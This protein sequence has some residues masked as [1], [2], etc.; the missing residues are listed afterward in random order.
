MGASLESLSGSMNTHASIGFKSNF[1]VGTTA[2]LSFSYSPTHP[3]PYDVYVNRDLASLSSERELNGPRV[4]LDIYGLDHK[5][6]LSRIMDV[7]FEKNVNTIH[8]AEIPRNEWHV[9]IDVTIVD[10]VSSDFGFVVQV[11]T[12]K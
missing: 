6:I 7:N 11:A 1:P 8:V 10:P 9:Y 5:L 4:K 3:Y 12:G 2:S